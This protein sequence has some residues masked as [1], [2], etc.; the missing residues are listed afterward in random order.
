M[1][2]RRSG[3]GEK[4]GWNEDAWGWMVTN[5]KERRVREG[6]Y[7]KADVSKRNEAED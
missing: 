4:E 5:G 6:R 2:W 7:S 1:V 3:R